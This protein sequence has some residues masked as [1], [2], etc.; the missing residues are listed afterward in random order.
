MYVRLTSCPLFSTPNTGQPTLYSVRCKRE[1]VRERGG[2]EVGISQ[3]DLGYGRATAAALNE[4]SR[5]ANC[6]CP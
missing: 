2:A 3:G 4:I 5:A 6:P 1:E